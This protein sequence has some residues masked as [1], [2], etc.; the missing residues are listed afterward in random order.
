MLLEEVSSSLYATL[1]PLY[2][3]THSIE[4][5]CQ[6]VYLLRTEI[7]S[8]HLEQRGKSVEAFTPIVLRMLQDIQERLTFLAQSFI[9]AMI[10]S[11]EPEPQDLN[12]PQRLLGTHVTCHT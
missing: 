9:R 2:I 11:Y 4:L 8:D 1:R 5:L 10:S 7:I 3:R 6:L 12:Y